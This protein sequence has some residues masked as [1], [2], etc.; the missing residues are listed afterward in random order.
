MMEDIL[1]RLDFTVLKE[2]LKGFLVQ[3]GI[4]I[5]IREL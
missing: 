4:I 3:S 1:V 2:A 5:Q